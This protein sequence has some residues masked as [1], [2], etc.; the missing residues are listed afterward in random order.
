MPPKADNVKIYTT[1]AK[2]LIQTLI[3]FRDVLKEF[4]SED[5]ESDLSQLK[6]HLELVKPTLSEYRGVIEQFAV[7]DVSL[8]DYTS[9][10][11]FTKDYIKL[12]ADAEKILH[13]V[14]GKFS[15]FN[16]KSSS[17]GSLKSCG[18]S[19]SRDNVKLPRITLPSFDG[20]PSEYRGFI[21]TFEALVDSNQDLSETEK[22]LYLKNCLT[23]T[24]AE[25]IKGMPAADTNYDLA[26]ELLAERFNNRRLLI[27]SQ[28]DAL[29]ESPA[30]TKDT[31]LRQLYDKFI[32]HCRAL[33][34]EKVDDTEYKAAVLS[35]IVQKKA[36][37]R[38]SNA[39]SKAFPKKIPSVDEIKNFLSTNCNIIDDSRNI[40]S[41]NSSS[42]NKT[43]NSS[44]TLNFSKG[45]NNTKN[46]HVLAQTVQ[47]T[48]LVCKEQHSVPQCPTLLSMPIKARFRKV[49]SVNLCV[50]CLLHKKSKC[51]SSIDCKFCQKR[52]HHL[53]CFQQEQNLV[54]P[55]KNSI[56]SEP[57][58]DTIETSI[59][60]TVCNFS[61]NSEVLLPTVQV[62]AA[63]PN[64]FVNVRA[65]LDTGSQ[66]NFI[67][68]DLCKRLNL[69]CYPI[70]LKL[71]GINC[72]VSACTK[73]TNLKISSTTGKYQSTIK[74]L[75]IPKIT[76]ALPRISFN[77]KTLKIPNHIRLADPEFN[78]SC[79]IDVL[80]GST[81]VFKVI[82]PEKIPLGDGKPML[83]NTLLGWVVIGDM[84][85]RHYS[86]SQLSANASLSTTCL[87]V[88]VNSSLQDLNQT[89]MKFWEVDNIKPSSK[90][91]LLS[92]EEKFCEEHF[93]ETVGNDETGRFVVS[94]PFNQRLS[95]LGESK[96]IA[97]RRFFNLE[98]RLHKKPSLFKEY[99][100]FMSEYEK[101]GHMT[102]ISENSCSSGVSCSII[103]A[104][105][106]PVDVT[107]VPLQY[108]PHHAVIK[109]SSLTTKLRVVFDASSKSSSGVSVNDTQIVGPQVQ[110]NLYDVLL[111]FR[112]H[113]VAICGDIAKMYRMINV[114][115]AE[116]QFQ[117]ILWRSDPSRPLHTYRLNTITY[118]T[119]SASFLAT[120]CL[121]HLSNLNKESYPEASKI[122]SDNFYMDDLLFST[123]TV[124]D[125]V[126]IKRQISDILGSA[127][128]I[129]RKFL[130][131]KPEVLNEISNSDNV[132]H[133]TVPIGER[134]DSKMLGLHW[135]SEKDVLFCKV[136]LTMQVLV[137][138]KR[139]VLSSIAKVF[140]PLGLFT[141][142]TVRGKL[143]M[144]D[145]WQAKLDWD[146]ALAPDIVSKWSELEYQLQRLVELKVRRCVIPSSY[147]QI[148]LHG[149]SDASSIAY[150]VCIYI[151][152]VLSD[153]RI[154]SNLLTSKSRVAPLR[155]ITIP[156]LELCAAVLLS[157]LT[158]NIIDIMKIQ[159]Q[160]I[161]LWTDSQIVLNWINSYPNKYKIFVA[162]RIATI[163]ESTDI[164]CWRYVKSSN[165]PADIVSRGVHLAEL[166]D[167]CSTWFSG[168][169]F[170]SSDESEWNGLDID[171]NIDEPLECK[172]NATSVHVATVRS[173]VS[174]CG[175]LFLKYSSFGKLQR[176]FAYMLRFVSN[177]R[178]KVK[179]TGDL[180]VSE[181]RAS[182]LGLVRLCQ[183]Q[184]FENELKRLESNE[185][186]KDSNI[187]SLSP[188]LDEKG[189]IRVGG[190]IKNSDFAFD[191]KFPLLLPKGHKLTNLII[192]KYHKELLHCGAEQ[193]LYSLRENYWPINGRNLVRKTIRNCTICFKAKPSIKHPFMS[194]LPSARLKAV[195]PFYNTGLDYAGPV[196]IK[197]KR[198]RGAKLHKAYI[199]VFV[200]LATRAM[201]LELVTSATAEAFI[202]TF[203]RFIARRGK[204]HC[205]HSDNATNFRGAK[206]KID[207]LY[208]LI[209]DVSNV[210]SVSSYLNNECIL[211]KFI[212]PRS[213]HEGGIWE[214]AVKSVKHHL[215]RVLGNANLIFEDFYTVL[216]MIESVLN[217][218]PLSYLSSD[219]NDFTPLTPSHFLIGRPLVAL[220]EPNLLDV[221][222]NRLSAYQRLQRLKEHF[223][224]RWSREVIPELQKR[225]KWFRRLPDLLRV[226]SIVLL[227]EDQLPPLQWNMGKVIELHRSPDG[228]LRAAS[229][230]LANGNIVRRSVHRLCAL[231]S[232][233]SE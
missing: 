109:G 137:P 35:Y 211:W 189:C 104:F 123:D 133:L 174:V 129:I 199:C 22:F 63:G 2:V 107:D 41:K 69:V 110:D 224:R 135:N 147:V 28:L 124:E 145:L 140:D 204:P 79:S 176:V 162:N 93:L 130:S 77:K 212:N 184:S 195:Y 16:G 122:I 54:S 83:Q 215:K 115:P 61:A 225:S 96:S 200:C 74:F 108:F 228:V 227:Q 43:S 154:V 67:T 127:G 206:N 42:V 197:D 11:Q 112:S 165:N 103:N 76:H 55:S 45:T 60:S 20:S 119:A 220:P 230:Q 49:K 150:G 50:V 89:L 193:L 153:G 38:T 29:F 39:F 157:E 121:L 15:P 131:N 134:A 171:V 186:I 92:P 194:D 117:N 91:S 27:F 101:M 198:T 19:N 222:E 125:A 149:F 208:N 111:R 24:A 98:E 64:N 52:H 156:R 30:L 175:M 97:A 188:F 82:L 73:Y 84:P 65:L 219:P 159:F 185:C 59:G 40:S 205:I 94:I 9:V 100:E 17:T 72:S 4:N 161:F 68:E 44:K 25:I 216:V 7:H 66:S 36:D 178:S 214:G 207:S 226:N 169:L 158:C 172:V 151:R 233:D 34:N 62:L 166:N 141:P 217:S 105:G 203:K 47:K 10:S 33:E 142:I 168:P 12:L 173:D 37:S 95:S 152:C 183:R 144:Q 5:A 181:L 80:I 70:D 21:D 192:S 81:T 190:R 90:L 8:D 18:S 180:T 58:N 99:A 56:P 87:N 231:P 88:K 138:T 53:L 120:R 114:N 209:H 139:S 155:T 136:E 218:R 191:K 179:V 164:K 163:Q 106:G 182:T 177:L 86:N 75:V 3:D 213:P 32:A 167:P 23:G 126:K 132:D 57:L 223:W 160:S 31:F 210:R 6:I 201:H 128:F 148:Q 187:Q 85:Y 202:N 46:C 14:D 102:N 113:E 26:K 1:R 116:T 143:L 13:K 71:N 146:D 196:L 78:M 232:E 48:C 170:L 221:P 118:G 229:V 51:N